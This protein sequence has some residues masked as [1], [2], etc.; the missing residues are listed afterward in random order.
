MLTWIL[1]RNID[2]AL[3]AGEN[4][5]EE[6]VDQDYVDYTGMRRSF[7]VRIH[8]PELWIGNPDRFLETKVKKKYLKPKDVK[9]REKPKP[10]PTYTR[11]PKEKRDKQ[12]SWLDEIKRS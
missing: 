5:M 2:D 4:L 12:S 3:F 11:S 10:K 1:K 9:P 8:A 6:Y 7:N